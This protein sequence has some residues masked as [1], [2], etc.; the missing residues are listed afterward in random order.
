MHDGSIRTLR[1]VVD[2]YADGGRLI[3]EGPNA[4][5]GRLSPLRDPLVAAI[6]LS[7]R[8]RRDLVAFLRTLTD[9]RFLTDPRYSDPFRPT[10]RR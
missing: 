6:D 1:E 3:T 5:D 7:E 2:F 4:G 10:P 8:D 9:R